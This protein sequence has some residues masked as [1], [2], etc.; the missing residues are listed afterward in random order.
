MHAATLTNK[1][2]RKADVWNRL[3]EQQP[4][5]SLTRAPLSLQVSRTLRA[6]SKNFMEATN[7]NCS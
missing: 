4:L 5:V 7:R 6:E 2:L 1:P 3:V